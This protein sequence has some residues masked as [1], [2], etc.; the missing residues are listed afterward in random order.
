MVLATELAQ[1]VSATTRRSGSQFLK[2]RY[3]GRLQRKNQRAQ[4]DFACSAWAMYQSAMILMPAF[5]PV[6]GS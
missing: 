1:I 6:F 2:P 4:A 3:S 5:S